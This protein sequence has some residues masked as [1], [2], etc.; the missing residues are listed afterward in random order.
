MTFNS[1]NFIKTVVLVEDDLALASLI[2]Y[3]IEEKNLDF[4]SF[5]FGNQ[6][7][8]YII[9]N[10]DHIIVI[11]DYE[12]PDT[13]GLQLIEEVK[14]HC[15]QLPFIAITGAGSEK[16]AG[17]FLRLGAMDYIVKDFGFLNH[18][19]TSFDNI[20][21]KLILQKQF[22]LQQKI[23][24]EK[25]F[26]YQLI[27]NNITDVY[28]LIDNNF[29]ITEISPSIFDLIGLPAE[30]LINQPF[31]Y[32]V[33][34]RNEWKKMFKILENDGYVNNFEI[35]II[36]K[37]RNIK[38]QCYVNAKL[39]NYYNKNFAVVT[40]RDITELKRLQKELVQISSIIEE[41]ERT[42]LSENLHDIVGPLL[43]VAKMQLSRMNDSQKSEE[44]RN[45]IIR[46][47]SN[48]IDDSIQNIRNISNNMMSNV[49]TQFG[50]EK[51][52]MRF[53]QR[54][55]NLDKPII[56]FSFQTHHQRYVAYLENVVYRVVT[57]LINNGVKH[58]HASK[59]SVAINEK[60]NCI[61]IVYQDDGIGF[62]FSSESF[63]ENT[64]G[65]GLYSMVNRVKMLSGTFQ[66]QRL[67]KG[68]LI[69]IELPLNE[70]NNN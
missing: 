19:D 48:I 39:I 46:E 49:L 55:S 61:N 41:Q 65:S 15:K 24:A 7:I 43:S 33:L 59:I 10:A 54:F 44:E 37:S 53:V 28:A 38:K 11:V 5:N 9:E 6:A 35:Q 56:N 52:I 26:K 8:P 40:L 18:F 23:I 42:K 29:T 34:H 31:F 12:L 68:I 50:L 22:E 21:Q 69:T 17:Q 66:F 25:E 3:K 63:F 16:I 27:F 57:E 67:D 14:K 70:D 2:K 1:G 62:D 51:S 58:S 4:V 30:M 32:L 60:N 47:I 36:N 13:T 64:K 45:E 20:L